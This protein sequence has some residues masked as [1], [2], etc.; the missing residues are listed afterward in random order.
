MEFGRVTTNANTVLVL[1]GQFDPASACF[2]GS[3]AEE[4]AR[5]FFVDV[6]FSRPK[7][8]CRKRAPSSR[9]SLRSALSRSLPSRRRVWCCWPTTRNS[10]A[11]VVQGVGYQADPRSNHGC[12]H[13]GGR[14]GAGGAAW[15][16]CTGR[17]C[18]AVAGGSLVASP[19]GSSLKCPCELAISRTGDAMRFE[20]KMPDLA[21]T[22]SEIRIARWIVQPGQKV[23]RGQPLLEV[24]TDKATMEVESVVSGVLEEVRCQA[25]EIG[26]RRPGNRGAGSGDGARSRAAGRDSREAECALRAAVSGICPAVG[27]RLR[28]AARSACSHET[29]PPALP[30][31]C[32][33][34]AF[35]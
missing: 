11:R 18:G 2:V 29:G 13:D 25:D 3:T 4:A 30:R 27:D 14:P 17:A 28:R 6:A 19:S 1:G 12:G 9:R 16:R 26:V 34:P 7:G 33:R 21:A 35:R 15:R 24:E 20:M 10:A 5:R 23:E 32:R 8:F 22:E 31:D